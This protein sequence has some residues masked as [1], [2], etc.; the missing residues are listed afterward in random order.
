MEKSHLCI[1]TSKNAWS[2]RIGQTTRWIIHFIERKCARPKRHQYTYEEENALSKPNVNVLSDK[3]KKKTLTTTTRPHGSAP[4]RQ[5]QPHPTPISVQRRLIINY[6][7]SL[8]SAQVWGD[9]TPLK[10]AEPA[11]SNVHSDEAAIP[12]YLVTFLKSQ[13][14]PKVRWKKSRNFSPPWSHLRKREGTAIL[15]LR[16]KKQDRSVLVSCSQRVLWAANYKKHHGP[17]EIG[18]ERLV[19]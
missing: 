4:P 1:H 3:A 11:A 17:R 2:W 10:N 19:N 14:A 15:L 9:N 16:K 13:S 6:S 7:L 8:L 18:R 12:T 5:Q